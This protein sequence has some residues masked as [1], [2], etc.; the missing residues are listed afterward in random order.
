MA[1]FKRAFAIRVKR[2]NNESHEIVAD[3]YYNIG[4]VY[5]QTGKPLKV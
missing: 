5:K 3:C 1:C 4:L 2:L